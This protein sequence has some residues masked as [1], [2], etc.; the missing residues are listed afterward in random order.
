M[1]ERNAGSRANNAAESLRNWLPPA[2]V[3]AVV[4]LVMFWRLGSYPPYFND[5][6]DH[7]IHMEV[8][9]VFDHADISKK[10]NWYWKEMHTLAAYESPLYGMVIEPGFAGRAVRRDSGVQPQ[11]VSNRVVHVCAAY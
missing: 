1:T 8:N 5:A 11:L 2:L 6:V 3:F 10:V 4:L 9:K 7:G